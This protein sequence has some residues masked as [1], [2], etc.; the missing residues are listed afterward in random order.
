MRDLKLAISPGGTMRMSLKGVGRPLHAFGSCRWM[1]GNL[2]RGVADN[3]LVATFRPTTGI[4]CH[5]V[6]DVTGASAEEGGDFPV[7]WRAGGR[8]IEVHLEQVAGWD[9]FDTR[10]NANFHNLQPADRIFRLNRA[11]PAA[12]RELLTK[13]ALGVRV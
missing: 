10:R 13:L 5:M 9:S 12:C 4:G 2:N 8:T 1:Q 7:E 6:T 11:D 3:V